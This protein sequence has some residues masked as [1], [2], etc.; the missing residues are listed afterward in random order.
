MAPRKP[1]EPPAEPQVLRRSARIRRRIVESARRPLNAVTADDTDFAFVA[2]PQHNTWRAC[3]SYDR[4]LAPSSFAKQPPTEHCEHTINTCKA[5][6]QAWLTSQL[7]SLMYDKLSCPECPSLLRNAGMKL[8]ASNDT[9]EKFDELERRAI[10]ES[11]PGWRWCLA[12]NC[13]AGT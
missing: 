13:K 12:P 6:I 1:S 3:T 7:D 10:K 11:V 2:L 9:Y 8:H 5:C 4:K